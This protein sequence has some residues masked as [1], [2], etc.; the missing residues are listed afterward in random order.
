MARLTK[1]GAGHRSIPYFALCRELGVGAVDGM[2]KGRILELRWTETITREGAEPSQP[3]ATT[4]VDDYRFSGESKDW[5][6]VSPR[7]EEDFVQRQPEADDTI[8]GP[9]LVPT[10]PIMR[11]AMRAVI[12]NASES[13]LL[14]DGECDTGTGGIR[15]RREQF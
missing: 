15:G 9:V 12:E 13:K 2:V 3:R 7:S 5:V 1:R 10:T 14:A 8:V 6:P 4:P 11:F